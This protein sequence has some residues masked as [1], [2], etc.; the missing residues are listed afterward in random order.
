MYG[1]IGSIFTNLFFKC[2]VMLI[3]NTLYSLYTFEL[4]KRKKGRKKNL[5]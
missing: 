3:K 1:I 2:D 4:E 5:I